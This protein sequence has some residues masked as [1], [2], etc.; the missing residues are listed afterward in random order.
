MSFVRPILLV[1]VLGLVGLQPADAAPITVSL[2]GTVVTTVDGSGLTLGETGSGSLTYD[3]AFLTGIGS[4]NIDTDN[5]LLDITFTIFGQTFVA[6][7]DVDFGF[8]VGASVDFAGGIPEFLHYIV[9]EA[10]LGPNNPTEIVDPRVVG[11]DFGSLTETSPGV[12]SV[13]ILVREVPE[14]STGV[15]LALGLVGLSTKRRRPN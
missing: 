3:D 8:D 9:E 2:E 5:G 6:S 7:D 14:P 13:D 1:P 11:I 10:V 15:L 4:E 12:F